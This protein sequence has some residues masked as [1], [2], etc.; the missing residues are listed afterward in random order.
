MKGVTSSLRYSDDKNRSWEEYLI[1][2]LQIVIV[3]VDGG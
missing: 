2:V 3:E 1:K